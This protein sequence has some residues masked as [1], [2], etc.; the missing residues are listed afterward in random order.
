MKH[1][2]LFSYSRNIALQENI[3]NF[4]EHLDHGSLILGTCLFQNEFFKIFQF[5]T[6][7]NSWRFSLPSAHYFP[8]HQHFGFKNRGK[9]SCYWGHIF[10]EVILSF[11]E[12]GLSS[13]INRK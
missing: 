2:N 6:F 3:V 4:L 9:H 8:G 7:L 10:P 13:M 1:K 11:A 12:I 5:L